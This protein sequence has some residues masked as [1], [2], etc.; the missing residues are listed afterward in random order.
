M[1]A[2]KTRTYDRIFA[3]LFNTPWLIEESWMMT[4]IE[5]ARREGDLEAL[6]TRIS[7]R[8]SDS[9]IM[10]VRGSTAILPISGP[11]FPKANLFTQISGAT[12]VDVLARDFQSALDD[13]SIERIVNVI[14]SPGGAVTGINEM[15]EMIYAARSIKEVTSYIG[16]TGAS[17]AYWL[18]SAASRMVIDATTRVGSIG[19]VVAMSK[20]GDDDRIEITNTASPN[21]RVDINT[22]EGKE[23]VIE[24]LDA[25]ADVFIS[26]VAKYRGV[27]DQVVR[28]KF[29]RGGVLVGQNAV[30]VGMADQ[31]GSLEKL[32]GDEPKE[33]IGGSI[34]AKTDSLVT[35]TILKAENTDVYNE[36]F[37][38]GAAAAVLES[39]Q[40]ILEKDKEIMGLTAEVAKATDDNKTLAT[41]I[42]ALETKDTERSMASIANSANVIIGAKVGASAFPAESQDKM[43]TKIT[44]LV[45]HTEFIAEGVFDSKSFSAAVDTEI[46]DWE[47]SILHTPVDGVSFNSTHDDGAQS[48]EVDSIVDRLLSH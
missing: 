9:Q 5:I 1:P 7:E 28:K 44:K 11:I 3:Q 37:E 6:E 26:S 12:S 15:A 35:A 22:E 4:L 23:V 19:V 45:D 40:I 41:R 13:D 16:G 34:M 29:G 21:K 42:V 8:Y 18:G 20:G 25:L 31:L 14:D 32:L 27:T 46:A 24:E 30:D 48:A 38:A 43:V 39:D 2:S 10:T 17:A 33:V 36:V 47:A